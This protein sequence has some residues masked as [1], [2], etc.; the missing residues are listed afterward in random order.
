MVLRS[1]DN[2]DV[3]MNSLAAYFVAEMDECACALRSAATAGSGSLTM[4][5]PLCP[6]VYQYL[7]PPAIQRV[8]EDEKLFPPLGKN[9]TSAFRLR[10]QPSVSGP[11]ASACWVCS[12]ACLVGGPEA[13]RRGDAA[14]PEPAEAGE[15]PASHR[16]VHRVRPTR[17]SIA[18]ACRSSSDKTWPDPA[19]NKRW[20]TC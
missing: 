13:A 19:C 6:D 16:R 8:L 14:A 4:L 9:Q 20:P 3:I 5:C 18:P 12:A 10:P 1:E 7:C 2:P 15:A 11:K 17:P